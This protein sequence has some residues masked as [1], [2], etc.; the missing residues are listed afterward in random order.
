MAV[1]I[2]HVGV[3]V[4][5]QRELGVVAAV[6]EVAQTVPMH[7]VVVNTTHLA[8]QYHLVGLVLWASTGQG[9]VAPVLARVCHVAPQPQELTTRLFVA[10][11]HAQKSQQTLTIMQMELG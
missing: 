4:L 11:H 9:V 8:V 10:H 1:V 7:W 6:Q 5:E 2:L 3:V